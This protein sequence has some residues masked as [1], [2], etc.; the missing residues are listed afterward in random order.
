M[1]AFRLATPSCWSICGKCRTST[2][3]I[4]ATAYASARWC[5]GAISRTT[6]GSRRRSDAAPKRRRTSRIIR[7]ATAAPSAAASR[8]P[9]RPPRC[10]ASRSPATRH[11]D[12]GAR[13]AR[14]RCRPPI[15]S[16]AHLRPR[17]APDEIITGV[18]FRPGPPA[19]AGPSRSSRAVAAT[20]R[21]PASRSITSGR[22][23]LA[24]NV[25]IGVLGAASC[26]APARQGRGGARGQS[27]RRRRRSQR[28]AAAAARR[29]R[30]AERHSCQRRLPARAGRA[31][32]SS[33][34]SMPRWPEEE[35]TMQVRMMVNGKPVEAEVEP[36]ARRWPT[37]CASSASSPARIW[38]ASTASAGRAR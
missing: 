5:G 31:R 38:A 21:S 35:S 19:G 32:W 25:H 11:R 22:R 29:G 18:R 20:S 2:D 16:W 34:R 15:S 27:R 17:S 30:A 10:P 1:M 28:L 26:T 3:P 36:R 14:D 37:A 6:S 33:A 23:G 12:R 24:R 9:I 13:R 7:S 4:G 8:M